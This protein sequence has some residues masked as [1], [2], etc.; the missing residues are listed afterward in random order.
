MTRVSVAMAVRDVEAYIDEALDSVLEQV[1][2]DDEVVVVDD[3]STDTTPERLTAR[4]P[5][6]VLARQPH[7]GVSAARNL[8]LDHCSGRFIAFLDGD[9]RWAPGALDRL[10]AGVE[11]HPEA[12]GVVGRTDEFVDEAVSDRAA[13]GLRAPASDVLGHFLGAMLLR[14]EIVDAVRFD[15]DQSLASTPD[16]L[17]RA[18]DHGLDLHP[19]DGVT[20]LRRLRPA[21]LTADGPAHQSALLA[22]LR[23]NLAR[24]RR[25]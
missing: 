12:T 16:W 5:R 3:G 13:A 14:R 4:G 15:P 24:S 7:Q 25:Q 23:V 1:G 17:S 11:A 10:V 8:S 6:I 21:S 9:D 22:A 19:L 18:R 20:L 2:P